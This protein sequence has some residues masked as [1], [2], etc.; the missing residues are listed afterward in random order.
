MPKGKKLTAQQIIDNY[1]PGDLVN[2][3][4]P[5]QFWAT[6]LR[7]AKNSRVSEGE[8]LY[9]DLAKRGQRIPILLNHDEKEIVDGHHRLASM[10]HINPNQFVN[11]QSV[12]R[13]G[14]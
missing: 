1:K 12:T 9:E 10:H 7:V 8:T 2:N 4:T 14:N 6:K 5:E 3:E 11:Y 13:L